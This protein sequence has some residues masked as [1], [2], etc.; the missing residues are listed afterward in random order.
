MELL[1]LNNCTLGKVSTWHTWRRRGVG[2]SGGSPSAPGMPQRIAEHR[3]EV[4]RVGGLVPSRRQTLLLQR[5]QPRVRR[6]HRGA[7]QG[8]VV[9]QSVSQS[10][11]CCSRASRGYADSTDMPSRRPVSISRSVSQSDLI[12]LLK[13]GNLCN[14]CTSWSG[15]KNTRW[16]YACHFKPVSQQCGDDVSPA[17]GSTTDVRG[18]LRGGA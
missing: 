12:T 6:Q 1:D 18:S 15:K 11:F 4:V 17:A 2:L 7:F 14:R 9:S 16:A 8:P 13:L 10:G 5:G 3:R